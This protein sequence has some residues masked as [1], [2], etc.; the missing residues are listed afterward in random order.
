MYYRDRYLYDFMRILNSLA[1]TPDPPYQVDVFQRF[2]R[3]R[4]YLKGNEPFAE[5]I[6]WKEFVRLNGP[7][8]GSWSIVG[9]RSTTLGSDEGLM[10]L[11]RD[12]GRL[13]DPGA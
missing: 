3:K 12:L 7:G 5:I 6:D 13:L 8:S 2:L 9:S 11:D 1:D 10:G 4:P